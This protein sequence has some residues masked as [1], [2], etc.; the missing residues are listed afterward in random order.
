MTCRESVTRLI[1]NNDILSMVQS[2][3][4]GQN[5]SQWGLG[6]RLETDKR[7]VTCF[8][9]HWSRARF[10]ALFQRWN[11]AREG[12]IG[13]KAIFLFYLFVWFVVGGGCREWWF[14]EMCGHISSKQ[15][16]ND[17]DYILGC[18]AGLTLLTAQLT[19]FSPLSHPFMC[20]VFGATFYICVS[21]VFLVSLMLCYSKTY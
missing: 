19:H 21:L 16:L 11:W 13:K 17:V 1:F 5:S 3:V 20:T 6:R 2:P 14:L 18:T 4:C 12:L 15:L 7:G 9:D 8:L 10:S